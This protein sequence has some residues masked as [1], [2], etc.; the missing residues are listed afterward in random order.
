MDTRNKTTKSDI[1]KIDPR[2]IVVTPNFNSRTDFGDIEELSEQI[3]AQGLLNPI[4]VIPFKDESGEEKYRLV[5]G[6]RR[7]RATMLLIENGFDV[8]RIPALYA[9]K[10]LSEDALLTQQIIRN[11]GKPFNEYE[12]GIAFK[13]FKD[14]GYTNAEISEKLGFKRWKVDCFLAHLDRDERIQELLKQGKITGVDVRHIYQATKDENKAV[15]QIMKLAGKAE[16]EGTGKISLKDL[17]F[18]SDYNVVKDTS[19]VKKGLA[20]LFMYIDTYTK[21]G[22]IE[23]GLDIY[24]VYDALTKG[25]KNLKEIFDAAARA[26]KKV[27]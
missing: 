6:E 4:T 22:T 1:Y 3:K 15:A 8:P 27:G 2:N 18:G 11:E 26:A 5:D 24:D 13:K 23:L 9:S 17:D 20:T 16:K 10:S 14:M 19:A 25:K 21:G 12:L 7:Y